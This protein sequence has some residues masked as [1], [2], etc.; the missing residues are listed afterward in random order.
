MT[1]D[2]RDSRSEAEKARAD[3]K[4]NTEMGGA[5]A[6]SDAEVNPSVTPQTFG[7]RGGDVDGVID[8]EGRDDPLP[9]AL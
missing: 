8:R 9:G 3:L 5:S 2:P 6:Q 4:R 7:E 1:S